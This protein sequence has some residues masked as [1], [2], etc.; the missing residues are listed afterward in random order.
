MPSTAYFTGRIAS[1]RKDDLR[2]L[3]LAL[4]ISDKGTNAELLTRIQDFFDTHPD[5]K[6][7]SRF[8][9]LFQQG[10]RRNIAQ[11]LEEEDQPDEENGQ[12]SDRR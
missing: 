11:V 1:F 6:L 10:K 4:S 9:S 5:L 12:D 2:A 8:S 7:N 3:A